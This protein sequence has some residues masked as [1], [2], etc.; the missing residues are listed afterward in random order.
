MIFVIGLGYVGLPLANALLEKGKAVAGFDID[1][2]K[3]EA[4]A[5]E[6][7]FLVLPESNKLP[8][9]PFCAFEHFVHRLRNGSCTFIVCVP[10]PV[11]LA[12]VPNLRPIDKACAM[13]SHV[14][15]EGDFVIFESTVYPGCTED[16]CRPR[17]LQ[18]YPDMKIHLGYSPERINPGDTTH[19][20]EKVTKI[21]SA[22]SAEGLDRMRD[23]YGAITTV[24]EAPSI[25]VAEAA[26]VI[27]NVQRDVNIALINECAMLFHE[28][29]IPTKDVLAAARTKWNWVDVRPG[30]V[31][32]HCIGVDPYYLTHAAAQRGFNSEMIL[33]G[34]RT[35]DGMPKYVASEVAKSLFS[36]PSLREGVYEVIVL[37]RTFKA[38]VGDFR[39]SKVDDLISEL[40]SFGL[41]V[42]CWDP[43][44]KDWDLS[45]AKD[46]C[47]YT[48]AVIYAVNHRAFTELK[49]L[50]VIKASRVFDLTGALEDPDWSL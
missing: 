21:I 48:D 47:K 33:A 17:L 29:G 3:M 19:T 8:S 44:E 46:M 11:T 34:R 26:K 1:P 40:E 42:I 14:L 20:L 5:E 10:T 36:N 45:A 23:I 38:D 39:N 30:L 25:Q 7:P 13:L 22:D 41:S 43:Y 28:M 16:Y 18:N 24:H 49:E 37:G 6:N 2:R 31:G 15:K 4:A 32:G 12:K 27:E 35:N 9:G 50:L